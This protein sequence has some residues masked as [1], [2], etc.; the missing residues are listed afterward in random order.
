MAELSN[1][2]WRTLIHTIQSGRCILV[3][4]PNATVDQNT[5]PP[6]SLNQL[7]ADQFSQDLE[8][9]ERVVDST[10]LAHV[11]QLWYRESRNRIGMEM[12]VVDF[13]EQHCDTSN[14]FYQDL[15]VLPFSLCVT[16]THDSFLENALKK[17]DKSPIIK[18]YNFRKNLK[19]SLDETGP[20]RPIVYKLFGDI[21]ESDSLVLTEMDLL[22]F[23]VNIIQKSPP[24]APYVASRFADK[25][26]SFLFIGFGF[27][28][29]HLRILLHL[30]QAHEHKQRSLAL[31]GDAFFCH[32]GHD[33]T[34]LFYK[35]QLF[36]DFRDSSIDQFATQLRQK[37]Q[38]EAPQQ[39]AAVLPENAPIVFLC[40]CSENREIVV[41]LERK[42]KALGVGTWRDAQNLRGG[43]NWDRAIVQ[44]LKKQVD[45]FVV[46]Q[47][48]EMWDKHERYF[49]T[50]IT[51]ATDRAKKSAERPGFDEPFKFIIPT[52][53]T[54]C[55]LLSKFD[56]RH[57]QD[58]TKP[59][60]VSLLAETILEDWAARPPKKEDE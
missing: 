22:D 16:T 41:D 25:D 28:E 51:V 24:I 8:Y 46:L 30:L 39:P 20:E 47:T 45:Y 36:L 6:Q 60:G 59:N 40:H 17:A 3:L 2:D 26:A 12:E 58:L 5:Q 1:K 35:N 50:E 32:P 27:Q 48:P 44:V 13:H 31:E 19:S 55:K 18:H 34:T 9:P 7:L 42:L 49:Y 10:N 52:M 14:S 37:Y 43:D 21:K 29:W 15:A 57:T 11:T 56:Q 4:G 54:A 53:L 33:L 23:L 38:A